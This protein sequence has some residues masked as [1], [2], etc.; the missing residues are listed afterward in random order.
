[1]WIT[2]NR[3]LRAFTESVLLVRPR[4][5]R[6]TALCFL[7]L[8]LA[9]AV[10]VM[11]R[12]VRDT[13]FLSRFPLD[14]LPWMFV[15][16]GVASAITVVVYAQVADRMPRDRMIAIWCGLGIA[17]YLGTWGVVTS[18]AEW[19]YPVFYVW[20][21]VFAN[22]LISQFWTLANDLHDA[23]SAKR[24]FGTIGAARVLGVIL[25]GACAGAVVKL[26]GTA[27]LLFV[28]AGLLLLIGWIALLLGREPRAERPRSRAG[29]GGGGRG[30]RVI[31]DPYV[32]ALGLM[33]LVAFTALTIG[34]YQFKAIARS[35]YQEDD[36]A[37]FFSFFYA[38][39]GIVSFVFQIFAT[40]RV[41]ARFGVGAGAGVMPVVFG[42]ASAALLLGPSLAVATVMKFADNGFQYTIHETTLQALYVPFAASVKVRTR[43]FLDAV[44][45]P[46]AYGMGG[47][48]LLVFASRLSVARLSWIAVGL[49]A[50]WFATI[51]LVKRRYAAKLTAT[52]SARGSLET[53]GEGRIDG[54]A[55]A[56]LVRALEGA[57]PR[58]TL[59][60]ID[61]LSETDAPEIPPALARL[62]ASREP[63]IRVAALE[64]LGARRDLVFGIA[65]PALADEVPGV[66]VAA[67][68]A[69]VSLGDEAAAALE[70][71]LADSEAPVR[72]EALA[73]L[74][75]RCG[76]EAE[77]RG[78]ARLL[79][80]CASG[81]LADRV[82]AARVL[83]AVGRGV[84][85][86]L[87]TLL[88]D[89]ELEVR[90]AAL[91]AAGE[92]GGDRL[93]PVLVEALR[94]LRLRTDA[95]AALA[96]IGRE[97]VAPV[98]ALLAAPDAGRGARLVVPRIL[99][100]IR[101]ASSFAALAGHLADADSR[102]RLRVASAMGALRRELGLKPFALGALAARIGAEISDAAALQAAWREARERFPS[103]LFDEEMEV[104]RR[105][106]VRRV[107]RLLE[108]RY[109]R[110][111]L[112][113]VRTSLADPSKRSNALEVLDSALEPALRARVMTFLDERDVADPA[114]AAGE[115]ARRRAG[116][117]LLGQCRHANPY[118]AH[119]A[120]EAL[121][122]DPDERAV[123][124]ALELGGHAEPLVREG[125]GHLLEAAGH[126]RAH[127]I[128]ET[129]EAGM[130]STIE[131][132]LLLRSVP[133]FEKLSGEDLASLARLAMGE[134]HERGDVVF[135]EGD[136]GDA[137][138]VIIRGAVEIRRGADDV[139]AVLKAPDV[140]GEMAVLDESPRSATAT[141]VEDAE[142]LCIGSEEFHEALRD[143]FEV[144]D[145]VIRL[146]TQ[147]LRVADQ[148]I[149]D[150]G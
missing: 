16:Y 91:R 2:A 135:N 83:G 102:V 34:D 50:V 46:L 139:I 144:A 82:Q 42:A 14:A 126:E 69:A 87:R 65:I 141:A 96:A 9:S 90:R 12:T 32:N 136:A 73:V 120:L 92:A 118:V 99:R 19:I 93:V 24:L 21:E 48:V 142:L 128:L 45:K 52:L 11:G 71:L 140:F 37:R 132:I 146:L 106:C 40:P 57:D 49:V 113:L 119:L 15:C 47:G 131:K 149:A 123:A 53:E 43:A 23:R 121:S 127:K 62:A 104:R 63:A 78:G 100:R 35:T 95:E 88:D 145:G 148:K 150:L 76:F 112:R 51:P 26:I 79:A 38:G 67:I 137:L 64:R 74:L 114:G 4:E 22:L 105:G 20:S 143:R 36:L 66:R 133:L 30:A 31:G 61:E 3:M 54:A 86:L 97:A 80:L 41:L 101:D 117:F 60:A 25:V 94:D 5:G 18:G 13:L 129:V 125:A 110:P 28:L 10:F 107:L 44:V 122:K 98:S 130:H 68:R 84:Q 6:R 75:S 17:T 111:M 147:R 27:Q 115:D 138:Y 81:D 59:G 77:L 55:R 1:M 109:D 29:A 116:E 124:V 108:L 39:A 7:H 56:V 134:V 33:L 85:G 103:P 8:L 89:P 72:T 70:P 58:I